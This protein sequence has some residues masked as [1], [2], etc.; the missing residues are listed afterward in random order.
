MRPNEVDP[1][2]PHH[3]SRKGPPA[4]MYANTADGEEMAVIEVIATF[5][6]EPDWGMDQDLFT[7]PEYHYGP[8]PFPVESGPSSQAPFHMAFFH[9]NRALTSILPGLRVSFMEERIRL[10]FDL[11]GLAFRN[12]IEYWGWR[13]TAWATHYLQD[14]TQPY[15]AKPFPVPVLPLLKRFIRRPRVRSLVEGHKNYLKNRH[16]LFEA[17]VHF[18]LNDA[19]KKNQDHVFFSALRGNGDLQS[20]SLGTIMTRVSR[21]PNALAKTVD[22]LVVSLVDLPNITDPAYSLTDDH[23][24]HIDLLLPEAEIQRPEIYRRF[25]TAVGKCLEETGK[26]TRYAASSRDRI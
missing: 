14:L 22:R 1:N 23:E 7:V 9:E 21:I 24:F 19:A 26:M 16:I 15:H 20:G 11:A 10:F 6:D 25:V 8:C 2:T 13:F 12:G 18:L 3:E 17:A 5:A 4:G